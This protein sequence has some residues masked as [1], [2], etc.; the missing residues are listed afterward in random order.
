ME[1]VERSISDMVIIEFGSIEAKSV[2]LLICFEILALDPNPVTS[3]LC[4][5]TGSGSK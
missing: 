5:E 2:N 1:T 3:T 4:L